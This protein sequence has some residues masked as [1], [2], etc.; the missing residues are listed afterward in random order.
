MNLFD[1]LMRETNMDRSPRIVSEQ[2]DTSAINFV[3]GLSDP[4]EMIKCGYLPQLR[5]REGERDAEYAER[6]RPLVMA[7][8]Q[9]ERDVIMNA[10]VKRAALDTSNGKVS[11]AFA[12][13]A[14]WHGLGT[15]VDRAMTSDEALNLANMNWRV[16]K[17]Q[18]SY[19]HDGMKRHAEAW[20]IVR[21]DTGDC[22]GTVGSRYMPVQNQEGFAFLDKVIGEYGARCGWVCDHCILQKDPSGQES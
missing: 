22:L 8:P 11:A 3:T 15:V 1:S 5:R 12:G 14:P 2:H 16:S 21:T 18:L 20:G 10:A 19:E 17:E 6:I 4:G 7:L 9:A 13:R